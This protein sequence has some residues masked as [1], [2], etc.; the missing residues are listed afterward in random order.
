M[1]L[2][3]FFLWHASES[4]RRLIV[5]MADYARRQVVIEQRNGRWRLVHAA[6]AEFWK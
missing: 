1:S 5:F 6:E 2:S 4:H 3:S